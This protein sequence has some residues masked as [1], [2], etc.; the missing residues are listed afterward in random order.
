MPLFGGRRWTLRGKAPVLRRLVPG[1]RR[2][3]ARGQPP[4]VVPE[5][6]P[7]RVGGLG[8]WE[9]RGPSEGPPSAF[10]RWSPQQRHAG[11]TGFVLRAGPTLRRPSR[12]AVSLVSVVWF[13]AAVVGVVWVLRSPFVPPPTK[14]LPHRRP[15][16]PLSPGTSSLVSHVISRVGT[17]PSSGV[18]DSPPAPPAPVRPHAGPV[19]RTPEPEVTPSSSSAVLLSSRPQ[20]R[21]RVFTGVS[22]LEPTSGGPGPEGGGGT[23]VVGPTLPFLPAVLR[24]SRIK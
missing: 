13:G 24:L 20:T 9:S 21:T 5:Y 10:P 16:V 4:S 7:P 15:E 23:S 3:N 18:P 6:R 1:P 8:Q 11:A 14:V 12:R 22:S 17:C 2:W 19:T